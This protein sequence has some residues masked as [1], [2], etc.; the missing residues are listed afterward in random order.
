MLSVP[1]TQFP[2]FTVFKDLFDVIFSPDPKAAFPLNRFVK[3][4]TKSSLSEKRL[5]ETNIS[6]RTDFEKKHVLKNFKCNF[7]PYTVKK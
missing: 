1:N 3:M 7:H 6:V 5:N 4:H 2:P